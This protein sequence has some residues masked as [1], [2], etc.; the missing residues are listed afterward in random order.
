MTYEKV[1]DVLL[2]LLLL[3]LLF[4]VISFCFVS[5]SKLMLLLFLLLLLLFR[6]VLFLVIF[7]FCCSRRMRENLLSIENFRF[8][9]FF[10]LEIGFLTNFLTENSF[11]NFLNSMFHVCEK[12]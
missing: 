8:N 4:F 12:F 7:Y 3:L 2:L 9:T 10:K 11:L 5:C 1:V 6:F